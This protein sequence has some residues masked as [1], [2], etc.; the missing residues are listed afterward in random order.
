MQDP[1]RKQQT[2]HGRQKERESGANIIMNRKHPR[3]L[4][5]MQRHGTLLPFG[6]ECKKQYGILA[7]LYGNACGESGCVA[8]RKMK[9]D[10]KMA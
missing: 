5:N 10:G 3:S 2:S 1:S 9:Y 4:R 8:Q 6:C 7:R